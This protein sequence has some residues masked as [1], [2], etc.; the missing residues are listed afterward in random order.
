MSLKDLFEQ[1][2]YQEILDQVKQLEEKG[3]SSSR[4][5]AEQVD[6]TYYQSRALGRL[7][8]HEK[9]LLVVTQIRERISPIQ[10]KIITLKLL[11]ANFYA[12]YLQEQYKETTS[13]LQEGDFIIKSLSGTERERG[14]EWVALYYNIQGISNFQKGEFILALDHLNHSLELYE[15]LEE[16]IDIL[17][18]IYNIGIIN[19]TIGN[20]SVELLQRGLSIAEEYNQ[21]WYVADMLIMI[22]WMLTRKGEVNGALKYAQRG[23]ALIKTHGDKEGLANT[24]NCLG[25]VY[26]AKGELDTSLRHLHHSLS[27]YKELENQ[28]A[29]G[30]LLNNIGHVYWLKNDL[31]K[32]L[33]YHQRSLTLREEIEVDM[34]IVESLGNLI[35]VSLGQQNYDQARIYIDQIQKMHERHSENFYRI[36]KLYFEAL[37]LKQSGRMRDKARAQGLFKDIIN[38]KHELLGFKYESMIQSCELLLIEMKSF[39]DPRALEEA[40]ILVQQLHSLSRN[41]PTYFIEILLLESKFAVIEGDFQQAFKH[42]EEAQRITED[43]KLELLN[44][45]VRI[46]HEHLEKELDNWREIFERN[47]PLQERLKRARVEEY[48]IEAKKLVTPLQSPVH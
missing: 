16:P 11:I 33:D 20:Q 34:D 40:K 18:P 7:G 32:A 27:L 43:R 26:R 10:D 44:Q 36:N 29:I 45:R 31:T 42:L 17:L 2:K 14:M 8:Q 19:L 13:V 25:W 3:S 35:L 41:D 9:A 22:A 4:S 1:R 23:L 48:I 12:L 47:A 46:E 39:G 5:V 28:V 6:L 24:L 30:H 38:E 37:L 21:P 15:R